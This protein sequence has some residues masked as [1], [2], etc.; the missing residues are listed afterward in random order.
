MLDVSDAQ[1]QSRAHVPGY[2]LIR[3]PTDEIRSV[4]AHPLWKLDARDRRAG[5]GLGGED[6]QL[7][8]ARRLVVDVRQE[9]A[10]IL[11]CCHKS[12]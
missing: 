7:R 2:L 3:H 1:W 4:L 9:V 5:H 12:W 10:I 8:A 11:A 6:G